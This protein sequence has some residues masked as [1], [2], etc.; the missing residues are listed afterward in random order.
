MRWLCAYIHATSTAMRN[1]R[2]RPEAD[3]S[4]FAIHSGNEDALRR[5][6]SADFFSSGINPNVPLRYAIERFKQAS[7]FPALHAV[8]N[9]S[10]L[11]KASE[12]VAKADAAIAAA[13]TTR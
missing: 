3:I 6:Y 7:L 13:V 2:Y 10:A 4:R 5:K 11:S 12:W 8:R 1:G 9:H